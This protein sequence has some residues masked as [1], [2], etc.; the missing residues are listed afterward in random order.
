M[1]TKVKSL[2]TNNKRNSLSGHSNSKYIN[3][4]VENTTKSLEKKT[5]K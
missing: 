4:I 1:R 3:H 2:E 5:P